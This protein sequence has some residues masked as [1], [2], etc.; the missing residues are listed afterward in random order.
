M[1]LARQFHEA[2]IQLYRDTCNAGINYRP[3][4]LIH[5]VSMEG[6]FETA[7]RYLQADEITDGFQRLWTAERLDLTVEHLVL[8]EPWRGLF[9]PEELATAEQRLADAGA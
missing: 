1:D 5:A 2:M 9:T 6:G 3:S 7:R 8:Q 4:L